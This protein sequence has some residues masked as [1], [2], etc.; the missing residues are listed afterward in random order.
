[1]I[2]PKYTYKTQ[3]GPSIGIS[4][5][6]WLK[7]IFLNGSIALKHYPRIFFI[8]LISTISIPF[9]CYEKWRLNKK[10]NSTE[11]LD[12]PIFII[13]HWR[14]G[15]THL[16]NLLVQ[17]QQFGYITMLQAAFPKSFIT[18]NFFRRFMNRFLP[19]TRP[20]DAMKMGVNE[21]QEEEMALGN[22]FP[23]S[24]YNGWYF[25][26]RMLE[27]YFK[28]VRFS[29]V[30]L[31]IMEQWRK[32]YDFLLKKAT[33]FMKGRRLILK[34]PVNTARI[35]FLLDLYPNAKFIHIYRNPYEVY[36]STRHFYKTTIEA[37]MLQ[38]ITDKE[39]E[40]NIFKIYSE[41][42]ISYFTE[43]KLIPKRNLVELKFEDLERDPL[44]Q[45]R[46][47]YD[48]LHLNG[49]EKAEP[50]IL[51]YIQSIKNYKKNKFTLHKETIEKI[52]QHW[53]FTIQRWDY[54]VPQ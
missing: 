52:Y 29:H 39:I 37:F 35:K 48:E 22:M 31:N 36:A 49:Y 51:K 43:S 32:I 1:M 54:N 18:S 2:H 19:K 10:I 26:K 21:A 8:N 50:K 41:M 42:M 24:F 4:L 46:R 30:S 13:G 12:Q 17:D 15:T 9:R 27:F 11:L 44:Y 6:D 28:Y 3:I 5:K 14:S 25:P 23:Y 47:I 53:G 16:H 45:V 20:M 34:N 33:Y 7:L 38:R 40:D